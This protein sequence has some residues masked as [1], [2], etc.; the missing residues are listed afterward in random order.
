MPETLEGLSVAEIQQALRKQQS[1]VN[2]LQK[3]R[4]RLLEE[5]KNIEHEIA[6][7]TGTESGSIRFRNEQ[8]LENVICDV[9]AKYKKGLNLSELA[10]A[11]QKTG[12]KSGSANF[13]NVVYQ[14]VYKSERIVRD[15]KSGKY[16]LA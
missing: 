11:V 9:L 7:I 13:K 10:E 8:S 12:Y 2:V 6:Q 16:V 5:I 15:E 1:R 14:N 4:E 3:R